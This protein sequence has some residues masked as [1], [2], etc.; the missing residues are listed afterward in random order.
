MLEVFV[1]DI[2]SILSRVR[3]LQATMQAEK[4]RLSIKLSTNRNASMQ[5]Q[6]LIMIVTTGMTA[7]SVVSGFFGMNLSNGICGPDGCE[8]LGT[9][10]YGAGAFIKVCTITVSIAI[11]LSATLYLVARHVIQHSKSGQLEGG[12]ADSEWAL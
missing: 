12:R 4:E 11:A 2:L 9:T 3:T 8:V 10:D 7:C 1:G 5:V 6:I